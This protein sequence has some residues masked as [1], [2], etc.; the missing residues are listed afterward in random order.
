MYSE[1]EEIIYPPLISALLLRLFQ[2]ETGVKTGVETLQMMGWWMD[3]LEFPKQQD[4]WVNRSAWRQ[5]ARHLH[6]LIAANEACISDA[7]GY[8]LGIESPL[9]PQPA[10]QSNLDGTVTEF[11]PS[12]QD[13]G[14]SLPPF[15]FETWDKP[16]SV[17][18]RYPCDER[19]FGFDE[20]LVTAEA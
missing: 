15:G 7:V 12:P 16:L 13:Y 19:E 17:V 9:I 2:E 1:D 10:K 14:R 6:A 8:D 11:L 18:N 3:K 5:G 4:A 20:D